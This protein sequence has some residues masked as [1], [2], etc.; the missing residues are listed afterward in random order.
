MRPLRDQDLRE[1]ERRGTD[2][3]LETKPSTPDFATPTAL[4]ISLLLLN[5]PE[6]V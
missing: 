4:E 3:I 5:D 6:G 1:Q 2:R